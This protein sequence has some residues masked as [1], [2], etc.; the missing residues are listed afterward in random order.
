MRL[1]ELKDMML[2]PDRE[3]LLNR[4]VKINNTDILLISVTSENGSHK[5]WT[6]RRFPDYLYEK[7]PV[8]EPQEPLSNRERIQQ[9]LQGDTIFDDQEDYISKMIIQGRLMTFNGMEARFFT[10]QNHDS[11]MWLQHFIEKGL[12]ISGFA[13]AELN[14]LLL[15]FYIQDTSE[16]FPDLDLDKELDITLK[17]NRTFRRIPTQI[18]PMM[19]EFGS[20]QKEIRR[21][22][23]DPIHEENRFFYIRG[24]THYDIWEESKELLARPSSPGFT[25]EEWQQVKDQHLK[26]IQALCPKGMNLALIEYEAEGDIRLDFYAKPYLDAKYLSSSYESGM[27]MS[28]GTDHEGSHGLRSRKDVIA[29]VEKTFTGSLVVELLSYNAEFPEITLPL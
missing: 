9:H 22:F 15:T 25:D 4:L 2:I 20:S 23:Y 17:F 3:I 24:W 1:K 13:E 6:L 29:A 18:E 11:Y 28:F 21:S 8:P 12:D 14:R 16:P 10:E 19:L 26:S 7:Q 5:L 27:S